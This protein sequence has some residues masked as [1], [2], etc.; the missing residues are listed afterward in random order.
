MHKNNEQ[1]S[2]R[3]KVMNI[4]SLSL[5]K[6]VDCQQSICLFRK[7]G[8][9][10]S[11]RCTQCSVLSSLWLFTTFQSS[12]FRFQFQEF[13]TSVRQ[14]KLLKNTALLHLC[15]MIWFFFI[16]LFFH[17]TSD[18]E[19]CAELAAP[20]QSQC[21]Q[22]FIF[23]HRSTDLSLFTETIQWLIAIQSKYNIEFT[24]NVFIFRLFLVHNIFVR[25]SEFPAAF[26]ISREKPL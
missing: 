1:S 18:I 12:S 7:V 16:S 15:W 5:D 10:Q 4:L 14:W 25:R 23:H 13:F 19:S 21:K 8:I 11:T 9:L 17:L 3:K 22:K 20:T 24:P 26:L 6:R 2:S